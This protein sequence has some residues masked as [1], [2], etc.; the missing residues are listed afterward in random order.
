MI[1]ALYFYP[2]YLADLLDKDQDQ[3]VYFFGSI[4]A[5]VCCFALK[6]IKGESP[7][8]TFSIVTGMIIHFFVFGACAWISIAQNVLCFAMMMVWP[9]ETQH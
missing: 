5:L 1:A 7:K 6:H 4:L 8:K 2:D 9:R 3:V